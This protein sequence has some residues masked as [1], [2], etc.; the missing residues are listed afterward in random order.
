MRSIHSIGAGLALAFLLTACGGGNSSL[1]ASTPVLPSSENA[2]SVSRIVPDSCPKTKI[3]VGDFAKGDVEIYPQGVS[4]P[5]PCGKIK[6]SVA[7]PEAVFIDAKGRIYVANHTS[8]SVTEYVGTKL[9]FTI[10]TAGPPYDLFVGKGRTVYTA[11]PTINTVEEFAAGATTPFLT[12]VLNGGP[13]GVATDNQNNLY[14]SYLSNADGLS[15]VE[16]FA[17]NSSSGTDLGFTV[18]FAGELKFDTQ[19]NLIIGDRNNEIVYVYPPGQIAP[20]RSF[21]TAGGRPVNFALNKPE[22]LFYVSGFNA[23]QVMDYASGVQVDGIST[24]LISP[25]GVALYPPPPY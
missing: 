25:S 7:G 15:H 23:V 1:P 8:S 22:T 19:N 4:N 20:S 13:H 10:P 18:S 2:H 9:K 14:V 16:E 3:Y 6:A 21:P 24:G 12:L 17:P 5:S 11:E